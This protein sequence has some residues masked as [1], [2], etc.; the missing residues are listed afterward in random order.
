MREVWEK[1]VLGVLEVVEASSSSPLSLSLVMV[2]VL[3]LSLLLSGSRWELLRRWG[4]GEEFADGR[5]RRW[6]RRVR[7]R[8]RSLW[9]AF[10][11]F[12]GVPRARV[13]EVG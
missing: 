11:P 3:I 10:R 12:F 2:V 1:V 7:Y 5:L 9:V 13:G 6:E 8:R 4:V